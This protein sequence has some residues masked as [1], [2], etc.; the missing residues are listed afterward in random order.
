M[1]AFGLIHVA[2]SMDCEATTLMTVV[3]SKY[4]KTVLSSKDRET[5]LNDMI[6]LA[7]ESI[8]K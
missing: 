1:E 4:S 5:K 2:N 8:I 3:D 7:L 6:I